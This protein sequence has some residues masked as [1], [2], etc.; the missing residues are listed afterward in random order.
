MSFLA[1]FWGGGICY[2]CLNSKGNSLSIGSGSAKLSKNIIAE[3]IK[4]RVLQKSKIEVQN[5]AKCNTFPLKVELL[6]AL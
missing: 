4:P 3:N 6:D 1:G 5:R 2:S